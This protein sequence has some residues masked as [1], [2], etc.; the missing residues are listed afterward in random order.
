MGESEDIVTDRNLAAVVAGLKEAMR[1]LKEFVDSLEERMTRHEDNCVEAI[2]EAKRD[3]HDARAENALGFQRLTDTL[4]EFHKENKDSI[5]KVDGKID[6]SIEKLEEKLDEKAKVQ[7][8]DKV[9]GKED[10]ISTY[11]WALGGA[12]G[13]IAT[14][15]GALTHA[16]K[17]W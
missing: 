9:A 1:G 8:D 10:F 12:I 11:K 3:R 6:T 14:L 4:R 7:S 16:W 17:L 2:R 5:A 13:L 15:I